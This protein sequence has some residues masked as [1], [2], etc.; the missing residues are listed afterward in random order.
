MTLP[1][2][3]WDSTDPEDL[4]QGA[5]YPGSSLGNLLQNPSV[6]KFAN[7]GGGRFPGVF[8]AQPAGSPLNPSMP[9][10]FITDLFAKFASY[11]AQADP[12]TI[13]KPEDLQG[14]ITD[15]VVGLPLSSLGSASNPL[16][17]MQTNIQAAFT[18]LNDVWDYY[19]GLSGGVREIQN[20]INQGWIDGDE[21]EAD[22]DVF[23][24]MR[25]IRTAIN[26]NPWVRVV[27]LSSQTWNRPD[28]LEFDLKEVVLIMVSGGTNGEDG[29][30][31]GSVTDAGNDGGAP[32]LG[33]GYSV[34]MVDVEDFTNLHIA[35][36]TAGAAT[37]VRADDGAGA[38]LGQAFNNTPSSTPGQWGWVP[39]ASGAGNG[40]A[41]GRGG[42]SL[43]AL[44]G[45]AGAGVP[46]IPGGAGGAPGISSSGQA[47]GSSGTPGGS[48]PATTT[49]PC[50]GSG[51]GG[52]GG[53]H[54][55]PFPLNTGGLAGHG[56]AG[57]FPGGGG[58]GGGG[59]AK[60]TGVG[61]GGSSG[62]GGP[63]GAG[64]C[65]IFYRGEA[66]PA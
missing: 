65:L 9:L 15:F 55:P 21:S 40:G 27:A 14:L 18:E 34:R 45:A 66:I 39:S 23:A 13:T 35:I 50:G 12:A 53:A 52:G 43:P 3:P 33:G 61:G 42:D 2:M 37:V 38:I 62:L 1:N 64:M 29:K 20:G 8:F 60:G 36:G 26:G 19:E 32:G 58:G 30:T 41:G 22:P 51:G 59:K 31:T 49:V 54:R 4:P 6:S 57:G 7:L 28:P 48:V 63:G 56:A 46:A 17:Q 25:G 11:V 24:T 5:A 10:G 44:A 47:N 16:E